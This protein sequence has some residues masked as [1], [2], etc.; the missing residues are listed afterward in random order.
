M[1]GRREA[2]LGWETL[3]LWDKPE[4]YGIA[5]KRLDVRLRKSAFNSKR[6][7]KEALEKII[8]GIK[9]PHIVLSFNNEGFLAPETIEEMLRGWG[10]TVK[11]S[12][13]HRRY[14]GS[15]IGIY[16]PKGEKVGRVSHTQNKEFLF[17]ATQQRR[18]FEEIRSI[19]E[20]HLV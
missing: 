15:V 9:A 19:A 4:T 7:A 12:R 8:S 3:V 20:L 2:D 18:V 14:I 13:P 1:P 10:Y 6:S 17:V 16:N 11:L 5:K